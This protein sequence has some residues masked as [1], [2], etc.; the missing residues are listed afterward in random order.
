MFSDVLRL[1]AI[2]APLQRGLYVRNNYRKSMS[3]K[4]PLKWS[5]LIISLAGIAFPAM[6][7]IFLTLERPVQGS[8]AK[9]VMSV[10]KPV[11]SAGIETTLV[12]PGLPIRLQIPKIK[13]DA[14]LES[15][16]LTPQGAVGVPKGPTNAAWFNLGPRPGENGSAVIDGHYGVWKNGKATVFNNLYKL[17]PGDKLYV[18]DKKG[19]TTA[20]VVREFRTYGPEDD[21]SEVFISSDGKAHLNLI[22][23]EGIWDKVSKSY[24]K[25]L[26]VF[27]DR[28]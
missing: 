12:S 11:S 21:A 14:A 2:K 9:Q 7:I 24:S 18:K 16:G 15:V 26:V 22:T 20:F 27:T 6:I 10:A 3:A 13:V 5:W 4:I 23:C 8:Y 19:S 28:E 1:E 17:R 25:R